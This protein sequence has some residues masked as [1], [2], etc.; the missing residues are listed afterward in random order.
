MAEG[1]L[2]GWQGGPGRGAHMGSGAVVGAGLPSWWGW[3]GGAVHSG[4]GKRDGL[5]TL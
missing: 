5:C 1:S 3:R 4:Q 2:Q